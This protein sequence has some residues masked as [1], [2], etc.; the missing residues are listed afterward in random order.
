MAGNHL[1]ATYGLD[2]TPA[3]KDWN[4]YARWQD[5]QFKQMERDAKRVRVMDSIS[6]GVD[7]VRWLAKLGMAALA[8]KGAFGTVNKAMQEFGKS[9]ELAAKRVENSIL[10]LSNVSKGVL[11]KMGEDLT[12]FGEWLEE[13]MGGESRSDRQSRLLSE[14]ASE[15]RGKAKEL[16]GK[17]RSASDRAVAERD[18]GKTGGRL[19][20]M[21]QDRRKSRVPGIEMDGTDLQTFQREV[22]REFFAKADVVMRDAIGDWIKGKVDAFEKWGKDN[23]AKIERSSKQREAAKLKRREAQDRTSDM[24][25][26]LEAGTLSDLGRDREATLMRLRSDKE[27]ALREFDQGPLSGDR[28]LRSKIERAHQRRIDAAASPQDNNTRQTR[29]AFLSAGIGGIPGLSAAVLGGSP[30]TKPATEDTAR[31]MLATL[32]HVAD[33]MSRFGLA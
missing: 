31:Q 22:D 21:E 15:R 27:K 8:L 32:K 33:R 5:R 13:K 3:Q 18:M 14:I 28:G 16:I 12:G 19:F 4:R 20:G 1:T 9:G 23:R 6:G 7:S 17:Q 26:D 2:T 24:L 25:S 11:S 30:K 10:N 29:T